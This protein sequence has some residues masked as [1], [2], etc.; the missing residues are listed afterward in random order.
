VTGGVHIAQQDLASAWPSSCPPYHLSA[1][2][3]RDPA[4][5]LEST[6]PRVTATIAFCAAVIARISSS[7]HTASQKCGRRLRLAILIEAGCHH[8]DIRLAPAPCTLVHDLFFRT[9][10]TRSLPPLRN[11]AALRQPFVRA[12]VSSASCAAQRPS[13]A[14]S[15]RSP[16][17]H[18]QRH[19]V[20][21]FAGRLRRQNVMTRESPCVRGI[22]ARWLLAGWNSAA[23]FRMLSIRSQ[24]IPVVLMVVHDPS[25]SRAVR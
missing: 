18:P 16:A 2:P 14:P 19:D 7:C 20:G 15:R 21:A 9:M 10:A 13:P 11:P 4:N 17:F 25:C 1:A 6:L 3:A 8:D 23:T 5:A 24:L 22:P 12:A